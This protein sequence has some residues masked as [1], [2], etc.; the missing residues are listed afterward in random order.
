MAIEVYLVYSKNSQVALI[1]SSLNT[2]PLASFHF[3][4][5]IPEPQ[6]TIVSRIAL[7]GSLGTKQLSGFLLLQG[8]SFL[9]KTRHFP[10]VCNPFGSF[11]F[12]HELIQ[13][14][15]ILGAYYMHFLKITQV[16]RIEKKSKYR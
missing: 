15:Q 13:L 8:L 10:A 16:P 3:L 4:P 14:L 12:F 1:S 6:A 11:H 5:N 9:L 2:T 7:L